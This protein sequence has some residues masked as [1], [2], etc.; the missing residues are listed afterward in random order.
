MKLLRFLAIF[1]IYFYLVSCWPST[2][3]SYEVR[4][5]LEGPNAGPGYS[6]M[7]RVNLGLV[8]KTGVK[9]VYTLTNKYVF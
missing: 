1:A 4:L 6:H 8:R 2:R 9:P 5:E 7:G 3:S